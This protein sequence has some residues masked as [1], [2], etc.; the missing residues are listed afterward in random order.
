MKRQ[1]KNYLEYRIV[2]TPDVRT[3]SR[4]SCFFALVPV[5]GI[6]ADGDTVEEAYEK[7]KK[8]IAFHIESL[9]KEHKVLPVEEVTSEF[10]ATARIP[11]ST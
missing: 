3:G 1:A 11:V 5:L 6:A 2:I 7:V 10:I 8:L 4:R 9:R